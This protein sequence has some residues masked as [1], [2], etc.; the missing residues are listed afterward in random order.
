V[1]AFFERITQAPCVYDAARG[2]DALET[3]IKAL[4]DSPDLAPAA[5]LLAGQP[6][7]TE[8][9][10]AVFSA[11]PYLTSLALR[12][13]ALL[14]DCL[15]RD[16]DAQLAEACAAL[17][18]DVA[19]APTSQETMALLRRFKRRMALLTGLADLGGVWSAEA[20]FAAMSAAGDAV[21]QQATAFLFRKAREA[22]VRVPGRHRDRDAAW[23]ALEEASATRH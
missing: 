17:G 21:L 22:W 18:G 12:D 23:A 1:T 20:T 11:S 9:L 15:L 7:T 13:P 3:L 10:H 4:C 5:K 14:A 16:P 8:L 6:K 19:K 2:A